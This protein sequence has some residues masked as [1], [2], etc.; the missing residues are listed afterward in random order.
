[1]RESLLNVFMCKTL[2]GV[3]PPISVM[4]AEESFLNRDTSNQSRIVITLFQLI[5]RQTE[6]GLVLIQF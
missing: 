2:L 6:I 5:C 4:H 3:V 1:M